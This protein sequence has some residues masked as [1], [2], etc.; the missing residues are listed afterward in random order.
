MET[1]KF[2]DFIIEGEQQ[3]PPA[4]M[5]RAIASF[6]ADETGYTRDPYVYVHEQFLMKLAAYIEAYYGY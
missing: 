5:L 2:S 6:Y 4:E 3:P 1:R